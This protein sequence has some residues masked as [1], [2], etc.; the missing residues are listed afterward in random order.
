M[1]R[2]G[3]FLSRFGR[4]FRPGPARFHEHEK[5]PVAFRPKDGGGQGGGAGQSK[6]G[7]KPTELGVAGTMAVVL[8][9]HGAAWG[10]GIGIVLHILLER[11]LFTVTKP[12]SES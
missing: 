4:H 10:L 5:F 12:V 9:M 3:L 8:A 11:S 2:G 7:E 1:D 6:P